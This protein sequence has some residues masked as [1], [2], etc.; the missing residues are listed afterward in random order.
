MAEMQRWVCGASTAWR[1]SQGARGLAGCAG[2]VWPP[3]MLPSAP[4]PAGGGLGGL[5]SAFPPHVNSAA[6]P[7]CHPRS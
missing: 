3:R 7:D 1:G 2:P 6:R 4:G 5:A